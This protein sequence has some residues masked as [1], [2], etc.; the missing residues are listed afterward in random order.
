MRH[1][2]LIAATFLGVFALAAVAAPTARQQDVAKKGAMVMPFDVH[3]STHVFQKNT[4]GGIQ[5]GE[6]GSFHGHANA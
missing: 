3:N 2:I 5:Q 1:R 4:T 6:A